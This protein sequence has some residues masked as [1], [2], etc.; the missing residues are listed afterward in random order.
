MKAEIEFRKDDISIN[1]EIIENSFEDFTVKIREG[2]DYLNFKSVSVSLNLRLGNVYYTAIYLIKS[3]VT[4]MELL[5][6]YID[7]N[8]LWEGG[9][10]S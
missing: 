4:E 3:I 10:N 8:G 2:D 1:M 5:K 7:D 9:G 6:K